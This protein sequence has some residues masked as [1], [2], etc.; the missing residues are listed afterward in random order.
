MVVRTLLCVV[1]AIAALSLPSDAAEKG[2]CLPHYKR[3]MKASGWKAFA[4]TGT[5]AQVQSGARNLGCG[6]AVRGATKSLAVNTALK[7]CERARRESQI[8]AKCKIR[9]VR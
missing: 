3:Y 6:V 4:S 5:I 2:T 7:L 9:D 8:L 1:V